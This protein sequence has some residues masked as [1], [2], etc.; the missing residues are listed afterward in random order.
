MGREHVA[1]KV[2]C[3][4]FKISET[5]GEYFKGHLSRTFFQCHLGL[6]VSP[7]TFEIPVSD[8]MGFHEMTG[9]NPHVN[10]TPVI[11]CKPCTNKECQFKRLDIYIKISF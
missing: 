4:T 3:I 2:R 6:L 7:Q 9:T 10:K 5:G 8:F 1:L 11:R